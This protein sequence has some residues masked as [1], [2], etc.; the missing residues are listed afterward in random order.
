MKSVF[1]QLDYVFRRTFQSFSRSHQLDPDEAA[2]RAI[3]R[4][5]RQNLFGSLMI[6]EIAFQVGDI[7]CPSCRFQTM[8]TN[9]SLVNI[10]YAHG[11][12]FFHLKRNVFLIHSIQCFFCSRFLLQIGYPVFEA[13][14]WSQKFKC[15]FI[16]PQHIGIK[17][18]LL[19]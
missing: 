15:R 1:H 17:L 5:S 9:S 2:P 14:S 12:A 11:I 8:I 19:A 3:S 16:S 10:L 7:L 18:V 6:L 13:F 4:S